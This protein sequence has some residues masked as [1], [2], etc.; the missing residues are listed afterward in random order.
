[1]KK[2]MTVGCALLG[3]A[4]FAAIEP[5]SPKMDETVALLP[6]L[7]KKVLALPTLAERLRFFAEN[8]SA[9][10][11]DCWRVSAPLV[12]SCRTTEGERGPWKVVIGKK[13]D[14]S[15]AR[16]FF[17]RTSKVDAAS[18]RAGE[19]ESAGPVVRIE[20]PMANLE[21][22]TRYYWKVVNCRLCGWGCH[23]KHGC[24]ACTN[25]LESA[26]VSFVTEDLAPRWI[27]IEGR[28]G[29]IRDLGGR[30]GLGGRCVRQGLV[31]R[32]RGLNDNSV[33]GDVHGRNRLTVEDVDYLTGTLG[34]KTD[35]DLRGIGETA[36]L[37]VSPLGERVKLIIHPSSCYKGIFDENGMK[38][39]A[40][41][42]RVFCDRKNYPV[43]FHCIGGADRTGTVAMLLEALLGVGEDD[44]WRDYLTTGFAGVVSDASHK[45][46]FANTLSKLKEFPGD[47]LADKAA[48]FFRMIGYSDEDISFVRELLLEPAP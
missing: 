34:I 35:L 4:A 39:M 30:R 22:G 47:S 9:K 19:A 38:V 28:V 44:L 26:V 31:Y 6:D 11:C 17:V 3:A 45:K 20:V 43:Y 8:P 42:F 24:A 21:I 14:L 5:L 2:L 1:M 46:A 37:S 16:N 41:N 13:P 18:G 25:R 40:E 15:D 27:A 29:N 23:P 36:D 33:S 10:T 48:S 12:F 32:G 7:Q